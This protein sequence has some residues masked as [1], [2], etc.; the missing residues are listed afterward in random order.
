VIHVELA[1]EPPDFDAKVR[2]PGLDAIAELCG[3]APSRARP[4]PKR[5]Q[6]A[7]TRE[8]IPA[9][10]LPPF[11]RDALDD[12]LRAYNRICAYTCL[13]IEHVTGSAS[14]DHVIPKSMR[15]DLVY[16]WSNY[17]LASALLNARK[18]ALGSILDPFEIEDGLFQLDL[19]DYE[20]APKPGLDTEL[21]DQIRHT[22][23]ALRLNDAAC[24]KAR[25]EYIEG[26][27]SGDTSF[28][29]VQ[30]RAPFIARE[31]RRQGKLRKGD[32]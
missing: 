11:W 30:R 19:E 14:V 6:V 24:L 32:V 29:Y 26:Y 8:E 20:V 13:Y 9:S 31:L 21:A 25:E 2:R 28:R 23:R 15:W 7:P 22:I 27:L 10:K 4:G 3:E 12:M 1:A 18:G 5:K 17:R 16:E